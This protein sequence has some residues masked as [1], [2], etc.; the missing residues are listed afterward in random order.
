MIQIVVADEHASVAE[1]LH[2]AMQGERDFSMLAWTCTSDEM[3]NFLRHAQPDVLLLDL[4]ASDGN[5]L[6]LIRLLRAQY[7]RVRVLLFTGFYS[8]AVASHALRAGARGC[9]SK[10]EPLKTLLKAIRAVY[11]GEIWA[12][13]RIVAQALEGAIRAATH[14]DQNHVLTAREREICRLVARGNTNKEIAAALLI[15]EQTVK[16][17]LNRIFRKL[18]LRRRM[19]LVLCGAA[20]REDRGFT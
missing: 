19:D 7:P 13:R 18:N 6:E 5:G 8:D 11:T 10:V 17:H 1:A 16:S 12:P 15:T 20:N 3:L 2:V 9:L 4:F 14:A